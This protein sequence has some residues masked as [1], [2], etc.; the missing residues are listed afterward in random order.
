MVKVIKDVDDE[1]FLFGKEEVFYSRKPHDQET[2]SM[3]LSLML[4]VQNL[5]YAIEK[6]GIASKTI[7]TAAEANFEEALKVAKTL[8]G[9]SRR[10]E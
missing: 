10:K 5:M 4:C 6:S 3:V 1:K 2:I 8:T 9:P 7:M